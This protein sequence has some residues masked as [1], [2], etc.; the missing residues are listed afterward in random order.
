MNFR[1][2]FFVQ[3]DKKLV[4]FPINKNASTTFIQ[5]FKKKPEWIYTDVWESDYNSYVWFSHIQNPH[6]RYIKGVSEVIYQNRLLSYLN[7]SPINQFILRIY[8]DKHVISISDIFGDAVQ[9]VNFIPM[10]GDCNRRT[11]NFL[12]SFELDY[13]DLLKFKSLNKADRSKASIHRQVSELVETPKMKQSYLKYIKP[14]Y[15]K[16][17]ELWKQAQGK[18]E[19]PYTITY[20]ELCDYKAKLRREIEMKDEMSFGKRLSYALR[21]L[22]KS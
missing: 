5:Y 17:E 4:Y 20:A 18:T 8:Y 10:E 19:Y 21:F 3:P 14:F 11:Y 15:A 6:T 16:D 22:F 12:S 13:E 7:Q 1:E 9:C 2:Y